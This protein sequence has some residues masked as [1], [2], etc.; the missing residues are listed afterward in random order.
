MDSLSF[1]FPL[2][3]LAALSPLL[4]FAALWQ[5]KEWR[6]D[7]LREEIVRERSPLPL[8]GGKVRPLI[9][10]LSFFTLLFWKTGS[11]V[12]YTVS[13]LAFLSILQF[14]LRKQRMP[15]W[16]PKAKVLV[17][18]SLL[19]DVAILLFPVLSPKSYVLSPWSFVLLP[20]LQSAALT[21]AWALFLP[22]DRLMKNRIFAAARAVRSSHPELLV[23]GITG[24]V[25]K[26]TTKEL[27]AHVLSAGTSN[28]IR[29][30]NNP[31]LL[32]PE[33]RGGQEERGKGDEVL[34]TPAHVNTEVGVAQWM[35]KNIAGK[36]F[37]EKT[38]LIIE[39]GAYRKGEIA[40]LCSIV[41][42]RLGIVT[43]IGNQHL[44]LFGSSQALQ[45]AKG[46]LLQSLP[47]DGH[48]FLNGDC[49]RCR[50]MRKFCLCPATVVGTGGAADME[51]FDI[52]ETA[53]GIRFTVGETPFSLPLHGTHNVANVL[54]VIA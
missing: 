46:E 48:A 2:T 21:L 20:L 47:S 24:S 31:S 16:T 51:A 14:A 23:I 50:E 34:F 45:E 17:G 35:L 38:S 42:P 39:M 32:S 15:V 18:L 49:V 8:V 54:L 33:E 29:T 52:E 26:T 13:L 41:Q 36:T 43:F 27:L 37:P 7:R 4:T 10:G 28:E 53:T 1:L 9:V 19:F 22:V 6:W 5:V 3:L 25:G 30:S 11:L 44:A 40:N 12:L